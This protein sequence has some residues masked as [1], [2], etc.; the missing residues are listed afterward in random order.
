MTSPYLRGRSLL[1]AGV[2]GLHSFAA[3]AQDSPMQRQTP[4]ATVTFQSSQTGWSGAT[5][6]H[7]L[8]PSIVARTTRLI[9][10]MTLAAPSVL[11]RQQ[12]SAP[13]QNWIQRHPILVGT[14][15]GFGAGYLIGYLPGD[16]AVFYD[17]DAAESGL[18]IGG[19]GAGVGALVGLAVSRWRPARRCLL[20]HVAGSSRTAAP[21]RG[22]I[23]R[24]E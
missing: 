3:L 14:A 17:F 10:S 20:D 18:I 8:A 6:P 22:Q 15:I 23:S 4:P 7:A 21:G 2:I 11:V 19:I 12:S 16:D 13:H 5:G 1:M 24:R 9:E